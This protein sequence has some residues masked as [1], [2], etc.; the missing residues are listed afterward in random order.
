MRPN[1]TATNTKLTRAWEQGEKMPQ[2]EFAKTKNTVTVFFYAPHNKASVI[3]LQFIF[4]T[5]RKGVKEDR[6]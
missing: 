4:E 1:M 5:C 2:A 3:F 6:K